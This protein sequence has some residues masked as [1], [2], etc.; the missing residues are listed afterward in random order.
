[1]ASNYLSCACITVCSCNKYVCQ[2]PCSTLARIQRRVRMPMNLWTSRKAAFNI[3]G[4]GANTHATTSNPTATDPFSGPSDRATPSLNTITGKSGVDKK[5]NSYA[6][7]LGRKKAPILR[8][9][10]QYSASG[11]VCVNTACCLR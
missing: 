3:S 11:G 10:M 8:A 1:M 5:H 2:N 7:Y 9:D 4:F 6:R